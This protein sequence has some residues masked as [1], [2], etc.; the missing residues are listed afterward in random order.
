MSKPPGFV[1]MLGIEG[2]GVD[3]AGLELLRQTG[4]CGVLLLSRNIQTP[5]QVRA[6]IDGYERA[7]DRRLLWAMDHEGGW[8]TR[9]AQGL[10][11]FPGNMA[12]GHAVGRW[13]QAATVQGRIMGSQ[14]RACGVNVNL[15]PVLDIAG[16]DPSPAV[17]IRSLGNSPNAVAEAGTALIRALQDAGVHATAKHYP[18]VGAARHDPHE[19]LP[20]VESSLD[21]LRHR[22]LVPFAEAVKAGVD[23]VMSSHVHYPVFDPGTPIPATFSPRVVS[24]LRQE[25]RFD[26]ALI[27]DD[28][29]MGAITE[30]S[31]A[32]EAALRAAQA[33]HDILLVSRGAEAT[34]AKQWN[35]DSTW[36]RAVARIEKLLEE[37]PAAAR[38]DGD[39]AALRIA[40]AAVRI[41]RDPMGNLPL[42]KDAVIVMPSYE[43]LTGQYVF[44][45]ELGRPAD[46]V[47]RL[48]GV[49]VLEVPVE[50]PQDMAYELA[51]QL[52]E[53]TVAFFAFDVMRYERQRDLLLALQVACPHFVVAPIRN[54]WDATLCR[55]TTTVVHPW[56][57][58][59]VNLRAA[60]EAMRPLS[61]ASASSIGPCRCPSASETTGA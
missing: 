28:L 36:E 43:T 17:T 23:L 54:P 12:L 22:E 41:E 29:C 18:G 14:L 60:V 44:E 37:R 32:A 21:D 50:P 31:T 27:T 34:F 58:R 20:V 45:K 8:V 9:F 56:G 16:P 5:E 39:E 6:L 46:L 25:F 47:R 2:T 24:F 3:P 10:T 19:T 4:A 30:R 13:P 7:L 33:G 11:P 61:G 53:R 38:E 52:I 42:R 35:R 48:A 51:P 59:A 49:E 40:R 55:W 57:F 1:F 26:G 15:A